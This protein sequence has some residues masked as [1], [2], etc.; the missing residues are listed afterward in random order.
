MFGV[1]YFLIQVK[2]KFGLLLF[3]SNATIPKIKILVN[4][5]EYV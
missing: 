1:N 5:C 2:F 4:V 3:F